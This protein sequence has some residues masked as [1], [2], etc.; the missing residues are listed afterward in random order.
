M[1]LSPRDRPL[2]RSRPARR[3]EPVEKVDDHVR[4][5][6][7]EMRRV[8]FELRGVGLAA[9][10]VGVP[11]RLMLVCPSGEPGQEQVLINPQV[12]RPTARR[13]GRRGA[14]RSRA[15]TATWRGPRRCGCATATSTA[16]RARWTSTASSRASCST[17]PTT[18]TAR[19]SSTGWTRRAGARP[20][21]RSTN[22][23]RLSLCAPLRP[24]VP[25]QA[26]GL[27]APALPSCTT[28]AR[29]DVPLRGRRARRLD[30]HVLRALRARA[31]VPPAGRH[32]R[33]VRRAPSRAP[34]TCSSTSSG[35]PRGSA[36]RP[37]C[38]RS[39]RTRSR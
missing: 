17:K 31:L 25:L 10:Q 18:S 23:V 13:W 36:A 16:R 37:S 6:V 34:A 12:L 24:T 15:S 30:A 29:L 11:L 39:R 14:S 35:S 3:H 21:P 8:M 5:V 4:Q 20:S 32:R 38:S 19:C 26:S 2:A 22:C 9:P 7:A 1:W 27:G 33:R 28:Q